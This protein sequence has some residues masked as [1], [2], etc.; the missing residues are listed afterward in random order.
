MI[1]LYV[2]GATMAIYLV[3]YC[4]G[5]KEGLRWSSWRHGHDYWEVN[6][7]RFSRTMRGIM[8]RHLYTATS[9]LERT[10]EIV[11]REK[12]NSRQ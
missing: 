12:V 1:W 9:S 4:H 5:L 8:C 6:A 2:I 3:A 7:G 10:K 11:E